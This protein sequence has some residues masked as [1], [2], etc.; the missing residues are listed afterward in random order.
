MAAGLERLP[1]FGTMLGEKVNKEVESHCTEN[2]A[3]PTSHALEPDALS[4]SLGMN[5]FVLEA[6]LYL[7]KKKCL[8]WFASD[9]TK[10]FSLTINFII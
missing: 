7:K 1:C 5:K 6:T 3:K 9:T 10:S 2:N 8:Q 4:G